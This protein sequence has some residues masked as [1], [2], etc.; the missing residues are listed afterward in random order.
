MLYAGSLGGC[1]DY[2]K[3]SKNLVLDDLQGKTKSTSE[4]SH[5]FQVFLQLS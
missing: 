3:Y 2:R 5:S 1:G 4:K